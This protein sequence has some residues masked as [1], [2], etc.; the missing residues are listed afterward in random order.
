M[1]DAATEG[2]GPAAGSLRAPEHPRFR[3]IAQLGAGAMGAVYKA[4]DLEHQAHVALK[5]LLR[6]DADELV[7]FKAEFRALTDLRHAN[8]VRFGELFESSGQWF[9]SMELV[10]GTDFL[11]HVRGRQVATAN[12]ETMLAAPSVT[13]GTTDA[14][15]ARLPTTGR[16]SSAPAERVYD[17]ARLRAA[18]RE[19]AQGLHALHGIGKVH[20]DVKPGNLMVTPD[21]R[22]VLL[23]FGLVTDTRRATDI[24]EHVAGTVAYMA[25]EQ[26][27]SRP[28]GPEA[29]WYAVGVMLYEA[30]TGDLPFGGVGMEMLARKQEQAPRPIPAGV[31]AP[32]DLAALCIDLLRTDPAARPRGVDVVRRLGGLAADVAPE[33]VPERSPDADVGGFVG[34]ERELAALAEAFD[35]ARSG[36]ATSVVVVG[37]SGGGKSALVRR[38]LERVVDRDPGARVFAG[39]CYEGEWVPFKAF[40]CIVDALSAHI[41]ALPRRE[42]IALLP[43]HGSL[44][45]QAFVVLDRVDA[46]AA[47]PSADAAASEPRVRRERVF[48]ALREL[49]RRL[50]A[51]A[52]LVLAID[53]LQWADADST[54]LLREL[55]REPGAPGLLLV[56]TRRTTSH[57]A[58]PEPRAALGLP[59]DSSSDVRQIALGPLPRAHALDL[60]ERMLGV[61]SAAAAAL[62]EESGGHPL[63]LRELVLHRRLHEASGGATSLRLDEALW[64]RVEG[65]A[66][67]GRRLLSAVALAGRLTQDVAA[68]ALGLA[69]AEYADHASELR[70]ASLVRTS[71]RR[72][73]DA[74]EPYHDRVREAV[75]GHLSPE[76][77]RALHLGVAHALE[78]L[79]PDDHEVLVVHW[80]GAGD[81][82]RARE[83]ALRAAGRA[84]NA[85][86][87]DRA[88]ELYAIAIE[89][90]RAGD[91]PSADDASLHER[92]GDALANAG[93]GPDAA[94]AYLAAATRAAPSQAAELRRRAAEQLLRSGHIDEALATFRV[95]LRAV[96]LRM[97]DSSRGALAA[98]LAR[99]AQIRLR[100]LAFRETDEARIA[101]EDLT[102]I[103][104]CWSASSGLGLV[105]T[106][107]GQYFQA[108]GLLL[109]LEAGE[110]RRVQRA[111]AMEAAYSSTGGGKTAK[112]TAEILAR[113]R[114]LGEAQGEPYGLAF[115]TMTEGC[116]AALEGR[117]KV[118]RALCDDAEASFRDR[119][120]GA[121][122][123]METVRWFSL[124]SL[125]YLG[126]LAELGRR[127]PRRLR[128]AEA[129]GDRYAATCH[130]TGLAGL[131]W[132]SADDPAAA[133]ARSQEALA[134][135]SKRTFDVEHWWAMLGERQV[136]LYEGDAQGAYDRVHAEWRALDRSLLLMVQLTGIEA[137]HLRARSALALARARPGER[138]RLTAEVDRD[139]ARIAAEKMP[140]ANALAALLRAGSAATRGDEVRA[141]ALL[142]QAASGLEGAGMALYAAAANARWGRLVGGDEARSRAAAAEAWM[143]AQAIVAP[144]RMVAMLAPGFAE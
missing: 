112:R 74:I 26:A 69:P 113:A 138:R 9:F 140:W 100:G 84:E 25:P 78:A 102:R 110:P 43:E 111:L 11:S 27:S 86:A 142:R 50:A 65:V 58:S 133:R 8:W 41:A 132:L 62:A 117:W 23:D 49:F 91:A 70:G 35:A 54:A 17:E 106:A 109:A 98:F 131:A 80:R 42:A 2:G 125:A 32:P 60:A 46:I 93:R 28:V 130:A 3:V 127:V 144:A 6:V 47:L 21:G 13:E 104:T 85:L 37:E 24:E 120:R 108:R 39:R 33:L 30:L 126:E 48:A 139:A 16:G 36:R 63:F 52:P 143:R 53:D 115:T 134:R 18:L 66:P 137:T 45:R 119:C 20:R 122:W 87:F 34:R 107:L 92:L 75:V 96:G 38:F 136:D 73:S 7:R 15:P 14:V 83:S 121:T 10:T 44:L 1:Q 88:A 114:A 128:E 95:V 124:W 105:D 59:P 51:E 61:D 64:R 76:A 99:R 116:A 141:E 103:D 4:F 31:A 67:A 68:R 94:A 123:E 55:L 81:I 135:W 40:D 12:D 19:L 90:G 89:L 56:A 82:E 72:G 118:A 129:R 97:P 22:V 57:D 79:A 77:R 71:G 101:P 29:D 5:T